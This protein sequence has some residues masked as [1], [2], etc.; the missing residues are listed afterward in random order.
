MRLVLRSSFYRGDGSIWSGLDDCADSS[1]GIR[2][3]INIGRIGDSL[4]GG[5]LQTE[6]D[7]KPKFLA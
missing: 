7:M 6:I 1:I 5:R 2:G 4:N 3:Q